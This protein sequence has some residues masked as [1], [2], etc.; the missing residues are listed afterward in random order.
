MYSIPM[1]E[2]M[3]CSGIQHTIYNLPN[4]LL[5]PSPLHLS[6]IKLIP[7]PLPL[8]FLIPF[9]LH[10]PPHHQNLQPLKKLTQLL[11]RPRIPPPDPNTAVDPH[12]S[13]HIPSISLLII[14]F[15]IASFS[16]TYLFSHPFSPMPRVA[17]IPQNKIRPPLIRITSRNRTPVI[18]IISIS[19]DI[20]RT[21]AQGV[22]G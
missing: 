10:P 2:P 7:L 18:D 21:D 20:A 8:L 14:S 13:P 17:S 22:E 4:K 9:I 19:E 1:A 6:S 5:V 16:L 3:I 12:R 15:I 11:S